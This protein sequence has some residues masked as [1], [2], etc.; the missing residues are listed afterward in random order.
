MKVAAILS[1]TCDLREL[2]EVIEDPNG[3]DVDLGLYHADWLEYNNGKS[4]KVSF[5]DYL[6]N[7][8]GIVVKQIVLT[9]Y[10]NPK[11]R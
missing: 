9:P 7:A 10:I 6:K 1:R 5:E 2:Y 4:Y 8:T 3:R 11:L